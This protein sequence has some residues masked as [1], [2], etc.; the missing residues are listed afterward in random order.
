MLTIIAHENKMRGGEMVEGT[1]NRS[2]LGW[3]ESGCSSGGPWE[4]FQS[5]RRDSEGTAGGAQVGRG[6]R[7]WRRSV[8]K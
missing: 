5:G 2:V 7:L 8:L 6:A 4:G 3:R 1:E